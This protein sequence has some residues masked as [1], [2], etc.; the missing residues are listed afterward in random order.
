MTAEPLPADVPRIARVL[1]LIQENAPGQKL[2][3]L[4]LACR[5]GS[6][7]EALAL[8]GMDV[9]GIE[10]R[11]ENLDKAPELPNITYELADVR[12][13]S[14]KKHGLFDVTLCLGLLYHLDAQEALDLLRAIADVTTRFVILDTHV[15]AN[16]HAVQLEGCELFGH[17][18]AEPDGPWSSIGNKTSW[19][20]T[21]ESL[22]K[23][24]LMACL[25]VQEVEAPQGIDP[26][27]R[28]FLLRET[29][30]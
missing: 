29:A 9:V 23:L 15:S 2:R 8:A 28:W 6:F 27:R 20:F 14:R 10:G 12:S 4:D 19:W 16:K 22:H 3:V 17:S 25:D 5:A 1:D 11:Q 7:C 21:E 24:S 30:Q 18:Y 13:L 26:D